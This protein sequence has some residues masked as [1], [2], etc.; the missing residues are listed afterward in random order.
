[1]SR[2]DLLP[3][4]WDAV[5]GGNAAEEQWLV[6]RGRKLEAS[7]RW[8]D[9]LIQVQRALQEHGSEFQCSPEVLGS[10]PLAATWYV[11]LFWL[12]A[13]DPW[14]YK[15]RAAVVRAEAETCFIR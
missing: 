8:A 14:K 7:H 2:L 10:I 11:S 15:E 6:A 12:R 4:D 1:M 13:N 5:I 3:P 9:D